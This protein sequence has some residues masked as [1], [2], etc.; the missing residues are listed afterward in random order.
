M[1]AIC[2]MYS[3]M[4][5]QCLNRFWRE[6]RTALAGMFRLAAKLYSAPV[7]AAAERADINERAEYILDTYGDSILRYAYSYLHNMSD[8][9]DILQDTLI[10]TSRLA[11]FLKA[12]RTKK[13]GCCASRR[14]SA[15]TGLTTTPSG[16]PTN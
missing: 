9:E 4:L 16:K 2:S 11:R 8:A 15:R 12:L 7:T 1:E 5:G 13:H 10:S 14:T 3:E 6:A